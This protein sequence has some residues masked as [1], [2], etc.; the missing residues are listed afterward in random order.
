[1]GIYIGKTNVSQPTSLVYD[2]GNL[3]RRVANILER[4]DI[5]EEIGHW[6]NFVQS[7]LCNKVTFDGLQNSWTHDC[8][9]A[10]PPLDTAGDIL[11]YFTAQLPADFMR[12]DSVYYLNY[13][14]TES[15]GWNL[16]PLPR[17]FYYGDTVDLQRLM[18]VS[19]M[20]VG[21]PKYYWLAANDNPV[22]PPDPNYTYKV[23]QYF[24]AFSSNIEGIG[25]LNIRYYTRPENMQY[26]TD[27]PSIPPEYVHYLIPLAVWWGKQMLAKSPG[28]VAMLAFY[29]KQ[30]N[31]IISELRTIVNVD[32]NQ[33]EHILKPDVGILDDADRIY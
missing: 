22:Y 6:I 21:E 27:R 11:Q 26:S 25:S 31:D 17:S 2:Y 30:Y 19:N 23:L 10:S 29:K 33:V 7:D 14:G 28:E 15:Y 12:L 8:I 4:D 16:V 1:M 20:S 18:E 3:I 24:P 5:D 32:E 9:P 13:K